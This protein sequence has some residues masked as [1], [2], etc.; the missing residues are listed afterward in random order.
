MSAGGMKRGQKP[1][2]RVQF[3]GDREGAPVEGGALGQST[4]P[5]LRLPEGD[6]LG[7]VS[8]NSPDWTTRTNTAAIS[9]QDRAK[10]LE[11]RLCS[12]AASSRW[13]S[14][15]DYF[16]PQSPQSKHTVPAIKILEA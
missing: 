4:I 3:L 14:T 6:D 15:D 2:Y 13:S 12:P 9:A 8:L 1:P 5:E 10:R 7:E 16:G 11:S